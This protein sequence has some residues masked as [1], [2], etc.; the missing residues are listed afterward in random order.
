MPKLRIKATILVFGVAMAVGIMLAVAIN[1]VSLNKVR[2]GGSTY[3]EIIQVKDLVADILP[4]PLYIIEAYLEA[5]L[6]LNNVKPLAE[7]QNRIA[8]VRKQYDERRE[9]WQGSSLEASMKQKLTER[10]H[11]HASRFWSLIDRDLFPA[12]E[13]KDDAAARQ[14]YSELTE[15]YQA[16]RA[17]IDEIVTDSEA[18][19]KAVEAAAA[20]QEIIARWSTRGVD[21]VLL[22]LLALGIVT[23]IRNMV[24]PLVRITAV[25]RSMAGGNFAETIP[26]TDRQ[27]EI[28]EMANALVVFRDAALDKTRLESEARDQQVQ[29]ETE[30]RAATAKLMEE[31]DAAVGG[32]MRAAMAGDF[33][34]RVPLAGKEG[35]VRNLAEALNTMCNNVGKAFDDVVRM[36]SAL[37]EGNLTQRITTDY[38]GAFATLKQN[39]NMTAQRLSETVTEIKAAA[40]EV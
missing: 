16:H 1:T 35:V 10:S 23:I 25:M 31:F 2:I 18:M 34:Q 12:I 4:P 37:S 27:D 11:T 36:F 24:N 29:A 17:V 39:A 21:A 20:E 30:R 8:E 40:Q 38:Q 13:R 32:V 7:A 5:G 22:M 3:D 15:K 6:V 28:G 9:F 26:S 14:A 33:S 19:T